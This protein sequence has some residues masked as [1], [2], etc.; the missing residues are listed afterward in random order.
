MQNLAAKYYCLSYNQN[1]SGLGACPWCGFG[2]PWIR[3]GDGK[4]PLAH[5]PILTEN[6]RPWNEKVKKTRR[7]TAIRTLQTR[8][9]LMNK[10]NCYTVCMANVCFTAVI[11]YY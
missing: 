9:L 10:A 5:P 6:R 7:S 4:D 8:M 11:T 3:L 2:G 1:C